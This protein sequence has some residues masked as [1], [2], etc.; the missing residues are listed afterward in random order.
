MFKSFKEFIGE[1]AG[2]YVDVKPDLA[3]L[4]LDKANEDLETITLRPFQNSSVFVNAVRGTLE[5]YGIALPVTSTMQQLS[6]EG[7]LTYALGETGMFVYV[8]WNQNPEGILEGY[9]QIVNKEDLD[10]LQGISGEPEEVKELDPTPPSLRYPK[11]RR[12]DDSGNT[13]EYP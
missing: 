9:A 7:E 4:Q 6:L 2:V 1:D 8:V 5:R 11:A 3:S 13:N 10:D 12:D